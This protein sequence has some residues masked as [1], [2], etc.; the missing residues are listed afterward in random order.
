[1]AFNNSQGFSITGGAHNVVYGHQINNPM[2]NNFD[3]SVHEALK[4]VTAHA[5]LN[6]LQNSGQRFPPPNCLPGT[7]TKILADCN[8]WIMEQPA[9][10]R[11]FW[12]HGRAGVGKSAIMQNLS[13]QHICK[14]KML[15]GTQ[16]P[17]HDCMRNQMGE[18]TRHRFAASF[19]FSRND[20]TRDKLDPLVAT[21]VYQFLTSEPLR[22]VLGPSITEVISRNP[23]IFQLS[24]EDQFRKL[25]L[26]PCSKLDPMKWESLPNLVVIDGLDECILMS[27]QERLITIIQKALLGCPLIFLVASRPEPRIC[28]GFEHASFTSSLHRLPIGDSPESTRDITTYFHQQFARLQDTH[29][30]LRYTDTSWPEDEKIREL[31]KRACGQFIFAV[32]VMKYLESD[33]V[34][35]TERLEEILRIRADDLPESPYPDLDLLYHQ[36]LLACRNWDDVR[37]VLRLLITIPNIDHSEF[38]APYILSFR[39]R[40]PC[41]AECIAT[42]LAFEAVKVE[43]LLYKLH[44]V[45]A[46]PMDGREVIHIPHASFTEF[47]SDPM[48]SRDYH[49]EQHAESDYRDLVAQA[50]LRVLSP[51]NI[52]KPP[53]FLQDTWDF[54]SISLSLFS[55][56]HLV[57]TL[58]S[59]SAG[60]LAALDQFDP[61]SFATGLLMT[62]AATGSHCAYDTFDSWT[63]SIHWA[64]A[65]RTRAPRT[66]LV[67]M[68]TFLNAFC[69]GSPDASS[70]QLYSTMA[71]LEGALYKP[72][73]LLGYYIC[74]RLTGM[75][76]GGGNIHVLPVGQNQS[77]SWSIVTIT[78][79]NGEA[80]AKLLASLVNCSE[81]A[82]VRDIRNGTY[83]SDCYLDLTKRNDLYR[84]KKLLAARQRMFGL[85]AIRCT[86]PS[87]PQVDDVDP[88]EVSA[89]D[90]AATR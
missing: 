14:G 46:V 18:N 60:L 10:L 40:I 5:A 80:I 66:F 53:P 21:I 6:A 57:Q 19:F 72:Q 87:V 15:V 1:M 31:V 35:P 74:I 81:F 11:V 25:I 64:K 54:P 50:F 24:F 9:S 32:T 36:I 61:Y 13:E 79:K 75:V 16:W 78:R 63:K 76:S 37:K 68:E 69:I 29:H 2:Y 65:L 17:W 20:P 48:R 26:E 52:S 86:P 89:T 12:I 70:S 73:S 30:A 77:P 22:E 83:T 42:I 82:L 51:C 47:L 4:S 28:R 56:F 58:T 44:A 41:S 3:S 34:L 71:F 38:F 33:D 45:I 88:V 49:V 67:K 39:G 7:R 23:G 90:R 27:S 62:W 84:L 8:Q 85:P 55:V 43:I 59:P